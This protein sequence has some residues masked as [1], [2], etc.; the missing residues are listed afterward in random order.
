MNILKIITMMINYLEI[1]CLSFYKSRIKQIE[2]TRK[3][4]EIKEI[5]ETN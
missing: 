4:E 1:S 5:F 3:N 2:N